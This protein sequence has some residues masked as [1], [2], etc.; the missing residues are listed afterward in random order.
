L[1]DRALDAVLIDVEHL[2]DGQSIYFYFLG[3]V[4]PEIEAVT[5]ELAETYE[6]KVRFR[7]FVDAVE[8]GCGP[9]CGTAEAAGCGPTGCGSC[10]VASAC[11]KT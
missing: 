3:E 4:T 10:A 6:T 1:K 9:N 11:R 8:R 7:E 5:G 2:F